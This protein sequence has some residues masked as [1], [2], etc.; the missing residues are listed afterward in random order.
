[1]DP[2]E[3][4]RPGTRHVPFFC[5]FHWGGL[6]VS[7]GFNSIVL[8]FPIRLSQ[9]N[10]LDTIITTSPSPRCSL[11]FLFVVLHLL[12]RLIPHGQQ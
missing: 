12:L 4:G 6:N 11:P 8:F 5:V 7:S 2:L 9:V 1:M 3:N 10:R